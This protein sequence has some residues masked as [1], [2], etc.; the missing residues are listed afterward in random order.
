MEGR[1]GREGE[2]RVRS[3]SC[4]PPCNSY[5]HVGL[6]CTVKAHEEITKKQ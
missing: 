4:S 6:V 2:E 3:D 1:G 5:S